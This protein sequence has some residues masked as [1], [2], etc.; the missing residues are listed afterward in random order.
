MNRNKVHLK[1]RRLLEFV[2]NNCQ[3]IIF[4]RSA[5]WNKS[6]GKLLGAAVS[7]ASTL[8]PLIAKPLKEITK[9]MSGKQE[10]K[11]RNA[12]R[13]KGQFKILIFSQVL[14]TITKSSALGMAMEYNFLL[15]YI[16]CLIISCEMFIIKLVGWF[17]AFLEPCFAI[18]GYNFLSWI[19]NEY[20]EKLIE[21]AATDFNFFVNASCHNIYYEEYYCNILF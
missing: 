17:I 11:A 8:L 20:N 15:L 3:Y 16:F 14:S 19:Q 12:E 1:L 5:P 2:P 18:R 10:E 9:E 13:K 4:R 21:P 6:I 7:K